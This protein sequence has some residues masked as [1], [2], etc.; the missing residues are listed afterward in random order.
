MFI[1]IENRHGYI[2]VKGVRTFY[3]SP[4]EDDP[5]TEIWGEYDEPDELGLSHFSLDSQ[6]Q[7]TV[8][9][10]TVYSDIPD[11]IKAAIKWVKRI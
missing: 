5:T 11:D 7:H 10:F 8:N 9:C 4:N 1:V 6:Y 3:V 2:G